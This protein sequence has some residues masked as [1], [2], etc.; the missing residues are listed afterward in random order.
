MVRLFD[1]KWI[2]EQKEGLLNHKMM[3]LNNMGKGSCTLMAVEPEQ[4]TENGDHAQ[5][6]SEQDIAFE[7]N[8]RDMKKLREIE[9]A[10]GKM[11]QGEYG[12]CE[13]SGEPIDKKR[14]EKI[15]WARYSLEIQEL[16]EEDQT[17]AA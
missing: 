12:I 6:Y 7:L 4:I 17:K 14:L 2:Q 8:S 5:V 3:L 9:I 13:E 10:L 15:P 1:A 16:M 11:A